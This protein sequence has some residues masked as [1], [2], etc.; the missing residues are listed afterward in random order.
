MANGN[1]GT[2]H[3]F[4]RTVVGAFLAVGI[5]GASLTGCGVK[6]ETEPFRYGVQVGCVDASGKATDSKP[7]LEPTEPN[8]LTD[9]DSDL[10]DVYV[11][12]GCPGG[13]S[14]VINQSLNRL[15]GALVGEGSKDGK[16]YTIKGQVVTNPGFGH[17]IG[18]PSEIIVEEEEGTFTVTDGGTVESVF[19]VD[20]KPA[21]IQP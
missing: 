10:A 16:W 3:N 1:T 7:F 13:D 2:N 5:G 18:Q 21:S 12:F 6:H 15:T 14:A 8:V 19:P 9:P 11:N 4:G 17:P 20:N